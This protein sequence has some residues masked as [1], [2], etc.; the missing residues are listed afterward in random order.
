MAYSIY[1]VIS[2][3]DS[4]QGKIV[5]AIPVSP[6]TGGEFDIGSS[7]KMT[8]VKASKLEITTPTMLFSSSFNY[9]DKL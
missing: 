3:E 6:T 2:I 4:S 1:K 5:T 9:K 8:F 7:N